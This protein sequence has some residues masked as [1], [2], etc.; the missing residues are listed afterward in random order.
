MP[1]DL[2]RLRAL[3]SQQ[4]IL[5][6]NAASAAAEKARKSSLPAVSRWRENSV[7]AQQLT[8]DDA[9]I[10]YV[11][12]RVIFHIS[13]AATGK[14]SSPFL[15]RPTFRRRIFMRTLLRLPLQ[16]GQDLMLA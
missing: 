12:R 15:L 2:L 11:I 14:N 7:I 1:A 4:T 5:P 13:A 6:F 8:A 3:Q 10:A 16:H 9:S